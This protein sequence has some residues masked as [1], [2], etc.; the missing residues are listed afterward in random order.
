MK[1]KKKAKQVMS[2]LSISLSKCRFQK[3]PSI[4]ITNEIDPPKKKRRVE[5]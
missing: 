3:Y 4:S 2:L 5:R 1:I